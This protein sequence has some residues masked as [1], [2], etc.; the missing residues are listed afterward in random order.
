MRYVGNGIIVHYR[1][2]DSR[3][4]KLGITIGRKWGKAHQRNRF[5]RIVREAYRHC[6]P[7][8]PQGLEINI[9]PLTSYEKLTSKEIAGELQ[10]FLNGIF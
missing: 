3:C 10:E 7:L 8:F 6:Y 4:S 2:A 5:K 1:L 9:Q